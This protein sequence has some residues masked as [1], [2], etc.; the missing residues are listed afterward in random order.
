MT[1]GQSSRT[2]LVKE[3]SST[4]FSETT[5]AIP[6]ATTMPLLTAT[7]LLSTVEDSTTALTPESSSIVSKTFSS[8]A[9]SVEPTQPIRPT[10]NPNNT[11]GL[12]GIQ[13]LVPK[14]ENETDSSFKETIELRLAAAYRW[15]QDKGSKRRKRDLRW[16]DNKL[17]RKLPNNLIGKNLNWWKQ[18]AAFKVYEK[19]ASRFRRQVDNIV[20]LVR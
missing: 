10:T 1:F 5:G 12:V 19:R 3:T 7:Q 2:T 15:G 11:E 14:N 6:S 9:S 16:I 13:I 17:V 4:G 20:V 8:V 18:S